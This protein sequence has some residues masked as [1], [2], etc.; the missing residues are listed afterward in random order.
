M[1]CDGRQTQSAVMACTAIIKLANP[2][3]DDP[4]IEKLVEQ[5]FAELVAEARKRLE[6]RQAGA[7]D[8]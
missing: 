1:E 3:L 2:D 8:A 5:K 4:R 6:A 7:I